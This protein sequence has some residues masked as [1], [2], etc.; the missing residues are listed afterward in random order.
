[1]AR[2]GGRRRGNRSSRAPRQERVAAQAVAGHIG[3]RGHFCGAFPSHE[4]DAPGHPGPRHPVHRRPRSG[5]Y[6]RT[7]GAR[8]NRS[9]FI[10]EDPVLGIGPGQFGLGDYAT[11]AAHPHN[12]VLQL[13]SEYGIPAGLA[14]ITLILMLLGFAVK[15]LR[16]AAAH[17]GRADCRRSRSQWGST[18][19]L[20]SGNLIMPRSQMLFGILAGWIMGRSMRAPSGLYEAGSIFTGDDLR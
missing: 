18:D 9:C 10:R 13:L 6:Q 5:Q 1:M 16:Q 19:S 2:I 17:V 11:F 7:A 8:A 14:G 15:H 20:V 12:V 4:G 3:G